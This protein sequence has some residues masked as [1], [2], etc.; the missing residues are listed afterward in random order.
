MY[1]KAKRT[2]HSYFSRFRQ[3]RAGRLSVG[4][5]HYSCD[6]GKILN[7]W[8]YRVIYMQTNQQSAKALSQT[9]LKGFPIKVSVHI[10]SFHWLIFNAA[11][12]SSAIHYFQFCQRFRDVNTSSTIFLNSELIRQNSLENIDSAQIEEVKIAHIE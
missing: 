4:F 5:A 3:N 12:A 9:N 7:H 1:L 11:S 2:T 6:I 8:F 10:F